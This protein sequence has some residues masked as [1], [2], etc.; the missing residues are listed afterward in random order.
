[1]KK[2]YTPLHLH[3][4]FSPD[5]L[6][7]MEK[8]FEH[9]ST[10]GFSN[11]AITDHGTLGGH[12]SFWK[13]AQNAGIKPL[14]GN[15]IYFM[16]NGQRGHL[17]VLAKN[18]IGYDNLI[19][20]NNAAHENSIRGFPI[21]TFDMLEK[22]KKGLIILTGCSASP[23][24]FGSDI[25]GLTF[26]G[27]LKDIVGKENL[28]AE[29]MGVI[30]EDNY[31]R[32]NFIAKKLGLKIVITND[33]HFM[34]A[35]QA[36]AHIVMCIERKGFDYSSEELFLKTYEE[37]LSTK[38]LTRY[39]G[40]SYLEQW[41]NNTNIVA[42]MIDTIDLS[43]KP[44][45]PKV[46]KTI[47]I[48]SIARN[49][50]NHNV[51]R[52]EKEISVIQKQG[53]QDYFTIL[54]DIVQ[55]CKNKG[56]KIGPGRGSGGGSYFLYLL[57]ITS[58]D[59][60][61]HGLLFERFLSENR[62]DMADFDLDIDASRRDEVIQ[63]AF[64]KYGA[65]P[66]ANYSTYNHASL[67]RGIGRFFH[68][69]LSEV[70]KAA[71]SEDEKVLNKF[72]S[73]CN[74]THTNNGNTLVF[75]SSVA[76]LAYDSM[77][78]QIRHIGK[79]AG[80]VVIAT[81]SV[82]IEKGKIAWTEGVHRELSEA[83]LVKFDLLGVKALGQIA[84]IEESV[85]VFVENIDYKDSRVF[86]EIFC[87]GRLEGIFQFYG[88]S[89][90][91]ELTKK[92][93]PKSIA[94]LSAINAL[95]R[96]GP[97]DSGMAEKYPDYKNKPRK[98]EKDIDKIL[99]DT[100]GV[101][102]YQEQVM[103]L[104]ALITGGSL[105]DADEAR[106]LISKGKPGDKVWEGKLKKFEKQFKTKGKKKFDES[107]VEMIWNEIVTFGRYGFN[108]S[109]S[110]AYAIIS[111]QMAWYKLYYPGFFYASLLNHDQENA[112]QWL[113]S[114][115]L[116]NIQLRTPDI[117]TS[118]TKWIYQNGILYAPLTAL[119]F[120]G[121]K[122]ADAF[123]ELRKQ[124]GPFKSFEE[125]SY[126]PK[127]ILNKRVKRQL[128]LAGAFIGIGGNVE[129]Y[130]EEFAELK[131]LSESERQI[132]AMG[133]RLPDNGFISFFNQETRCGNKAGF[134]SE[135]ERRNKGHGNYY[136]VSMIPKTKFWIRKQSIVENLSIWDLISVKVN[137]NGE[138]IKVWKSL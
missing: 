60:I 85:R 41:L 66:I 86:K 6:G 137:E 96:P 76:K 95:Y 83:G 55:F 64:D 63:Y 91:I 126:V 13:N 134:V 127:G 115:A 47:D 101:I 15:E 35:E 74:T 8:L 69:A 122:Q 10:L 28:F 124:H 51:E 87:N 132:E 32:P 44:E 119:K 138:G 123:I 14:F 50:Q 80:G 54:Y 116:D 36:K 108:K 133:Y 78:G 104:V 38:W 1:M 71:E 43:G 93:Q 135:I 70:E 65:L 21:V 17:T 25:D 3:T 45:L 56:I 75:D 68:I 129:D 4:H 109:H 19:A 103:S 24:Y 125:L 12:I 112:E 117:N 81:K 58:V 2:I 73:L 42:D 11:L 22:F 31:T 18:Q 23:L 49:V 102:V 121:E 67:I 106:K 82:P 79:H 136:V 40:V 99:E 59:P 26:A 92:V 89:G 113:Y 20:L 72:F 120:F 34:K 105:E 130:I 46:S 77:L 57:G 52:L 7:T 128:Y 33:T 9:A 16:N 61:E 107:I 88:S 84:E 29:V 100:Y 110:T 90:I 97:L 118:T 131:K 114:A 62:S 37:L 53:F 98:I 111:Y 30:K 94:D 48:F 27:N 5:G 39:T